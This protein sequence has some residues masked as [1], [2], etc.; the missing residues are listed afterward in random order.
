MKWLFYSLILFFATSCIDFDRSEH[1]AEIDTSIN[2]LKKAS[3]DLNS[4]LFDSIPIVLSEINKLNEQFRTFIKKDTLTL[5]TAEKIDQYKAVEADL[6]L[7]SEQL[8]ITQ[9]DIKTVITDLQ[10]LKKDISNNVGDRAK[11]SSNLALELE[12]KKVLIDAANKYS[13]TFSNSLKKFNSIHTFLRNF[14]IQLE[15][16]NKEQNLIP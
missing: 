1:I 10:N 2:E 8:P 5:E 15:M 7:L 16:K 12:N 6:I 13:G 11:Y 9:K 4:P 3:T 14:S